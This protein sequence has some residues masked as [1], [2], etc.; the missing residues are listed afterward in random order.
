MESRQDE[1]EKYC[2]EQIDCMFCQYDEVTD[3]RRAWE[4]DHKK[5][6][7]NGKHKNNTGSLE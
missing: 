5:E 4:H 3:C 7:T 2:N 6:K 1:F